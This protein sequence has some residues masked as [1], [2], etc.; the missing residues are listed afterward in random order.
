MPPVKKKLGEI[1]LE[2]GAI[3]PLQLQSA[4]GYHQQWGV[5]LG[6]AVVEKKFCSPDDV[7]RALSLQSGHPVLRLDGLPLDPR[8][9]SVVPVRTAEKLRAVPL[10]LEGK[11]KEVL[12]VAVA[13]PGGLETLDALQAVSGKQRLVVHIAHD[14]EIE[15][16]IGKLYY[17]REPE[18]PAPPPV[19]P[20]SKVGIQNE[21]EIEFSPVDE[22][23]VKPSRPVLLF[24][25]HEASMRALKTMIERA[26]IQASP[27][28]EDELLQ[29][30]AED[31]L[32]ASTLGLHTALPAGVRPS[33]KLII[34]GVREDLDVQDARALGARIYLRPPFSTEQL[35]GAVRRC[36][37]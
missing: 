37:G 25:W 22:V 5:P 27:I 31:V 6:Q 4:L 32:I 13:A 20:L 7:L 28:S 26:G 17:G 10:R 36:V 16:A 11:R 8:L 3:D 18:K 34:C 24:G 35:E 15:R 21:V 12:V 14:A 2:M 33:A 30:T 9:A 19:V 23:P 29:L 1:L